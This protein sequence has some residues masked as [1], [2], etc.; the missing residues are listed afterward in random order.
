MR[1]SR[2]QENRLAWRQLTELAARA[3]DVTALAL[4]NKDIKIRVPQHLLK[5]QHDGIVGTAEC[6]ARKFIEWN[7]IN[8][9]SYSIQQ[10]Y[11][12]LRIL[13]SIIHASQ[14]NVFEGQP[15]MRCNGI[16]SAC[17]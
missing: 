13:L 17:G 4:S 3:E 5:L 16:L 2:G 9:T 8:F 14:Q 6:I 1:S 11:Q 12:S 7:E 10:L 15:P